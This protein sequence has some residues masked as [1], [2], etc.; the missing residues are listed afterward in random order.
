MNKGFKYIAFFVLV[1]LL[2][3]IRVFEEQLFYDPYLAFFKNDY[4]YIDS[5]RQEVFKLAAFTTLRYVLN[6]VISLGILF[7]LFKDLSIIKFSV[8]VYALAYVVFMSLFLYFVIH[9][10]QE[11]Y[12]LFFNVRRFLI[13]PL[14][15][16]LLIPAFYY[17]KQRL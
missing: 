10:K 6:T 16:L 14:I 13:Q 4:L 1:G 7:V 11:D 5:P 17:H 2:V 3:L 12:Y 9:P 15:A 8:L